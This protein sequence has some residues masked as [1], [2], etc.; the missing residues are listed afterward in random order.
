M[1]V[2]NTLTNKKEEFVPIKQGEVSI[3]V[4]GPTVYDHAH[5]GN[6]RPLIVFDI[7]RRTFEYLGYKVTFVSNFTDVDDKIIKAAKE[8]GI[9]EKELTDKYIKAYNDI[10]SGLNL[11]FPTY[12]PRVTETMQP[13][14]D[15]IQS[16][17]DQ[18]FAYE[19][20]GDVY[21]RV[22]KINEYGMLSGIKVE[23]LI[24]GASE[25]VD[26]N[27]K[28]ES[29]TDFALWKKTDEGIQFE[30]PWSKGRPGWHTECVVMINDIFD[31]GRIDIHGGGQDLKFPHHENEIAQSMACHHHPIAN[32]WMHNQMINIDNQKMSKSLG[33]VLWAKDLIETLGCN[34]FKWLMLST[35]YRNPLNFTEEVL[36]SVKKEVEK[37]ENVL[38]QTS[39]YLQVQHYQQ[40]E[41]SKETVDTMVEALSDDLNTSLALTQILNQV[42][43]LNQSMRV[44][45]KDNQVISR[46]YQ[47]L[48]Q[49]LDVM[50]FVH[51]MKQ[52]SDND[53]VL[54]EKWLEEK[55]NKNFDKADELRGQLQMRGII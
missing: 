28:K 31:D 9:T 15:F 34:V 41:Y 11:L 5:I 2:F 22:T 43:V 39:L 23:D 18:G 32:V 45:D 49:M 27:D 20:D 8:E 29:S 46:E 48:I 1:K 6:A 25:R 33:N 12:S 3:Y 35:H 13:I 24:A 30:S 14:I 47:T 10:R 40:E 37:V 38:K 19:V 53:I 4:C 44:K 36:T 42:K 51:E 55:A 7:L 16:L 50:G 26:E 52:L 17:V 21:F 54:Y